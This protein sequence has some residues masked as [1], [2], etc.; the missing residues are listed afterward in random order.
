MY[1]QGFDSTKQ[2]G[3]DIEDFVKNTNEDFKALLRECKGRYISFDNDRLW[4]TN[5]TPSSQDRSHNI[6]QSTNL[7]EVVMKM[8]EENKDEYYSDKF[9]NKAKSIYQDY[10]NASEYDRMELLINSKEMHEFH[11][12]L[13]KLRKSNA[14][15]I[16]L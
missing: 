6:N 13:Q 16:I 5:K 4:G 10:Q 14:S 12:K 9:Y 15:C 3:A 2:G 11:G 7:L 1:L 8:M